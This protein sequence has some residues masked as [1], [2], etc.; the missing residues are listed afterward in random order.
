M[1]DLKDIPNVVEEA[2]VRALDARLPALREAIR[3]EVMGALTPV[4]DEVQEATRPNAQPAGDAPTDVLS[5]AV[6]S[7]YD[8]SSQADILRALLDGVAQF[9]ERSALLVHKAGN[10]NAWQSRG[11]DNDG[12][13]KGFSLSASS[14]LAGRAIEDREDVSGAA[15]EFDQGFVDAHGNPASGSATVFP[16]IVRDRVAATIYADAGVRSGGKADFS[17]IRVLVRAASSR[18]EIIALRKSAG[19]E[20]VAHEA[21][22]TAVPVEA[23]P[24]PAPAPKRDVVAPEPAAPEMVAGATAEITSLPP[25]EQE[26]HKKAKRFAK[27][28]VDEIKLYNQAKVAEGRANKDL[29]HRLREDIEKSRATYDKRYGSTPAANGGYFNAEVI[30]I[31]ADNDLSTLGSGFPQ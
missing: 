28:L 17:A 16:L 5:A 27:L 24:P 6:V 25:E 15:S 22:E 21:T 26:I 18:L 19:A 3:T 7:I 8:H 12:A 13:V 29:Y 1:A 4:W 14:G 30:R 10:L 2:L 31:L 23:P 20:T 9:V 11:F